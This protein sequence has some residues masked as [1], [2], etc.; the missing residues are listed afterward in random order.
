MSGSI[1]FIN[2]TSIDGAALSLLSFSY[3]RLSNDVQFCS[4]QNYSTTTLLSKIIQITTG[5]NLSKMTT[6]SFK[7]VYSD[8]A[9]ERAA[10]YLKEQS[11]TYAVILK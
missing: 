3:V 6:T 5:V 2:N 11:R 10:L 1:E 7:Q 4:Y 8:P 9:Y